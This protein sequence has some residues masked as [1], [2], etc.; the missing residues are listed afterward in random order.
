MFCPSFFGYDKRLAN[1]IRNEGYEV[2]LYDERPN[3]GFIAKVCIRYSVRMYRPITKGYY[4]QIIQ[5]LGNASYDYVLVVKGEAVSEDIVGLLRETYPAA[6][7]ILYLWDSVVNIPD[8][9]KRISLFDKVLTFDSNDARKYG[10]QYLPLPYDEGS[11][12]YAACDTYKYDAAFIGTA[13]SVRPRAVR[14]IQEICQQQGQLFCLL[15]F[16]SYA[17][18]SV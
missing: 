4:Q 2:D 1:A 9:V 5:K 8:C 15:L 7:F 12:S 6:K 13:H 18:V 17:G 14:Q 16:S 3:N 10:L 11:F